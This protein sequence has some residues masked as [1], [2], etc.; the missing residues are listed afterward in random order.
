MS[1]AKHSIEMPLDEFLRYDVTR[2]WRGLRLYVQVWQQTGQELYRYPRFSITLLKK[3][4]R[5]ELFKLLDHYSQR[6][7][8]KA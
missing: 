6:N 1:N 5:A 8:P 7:S 3:K 4:E 2:A